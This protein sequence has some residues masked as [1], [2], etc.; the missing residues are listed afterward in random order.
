MKY[1]LT[2]ALATVLGTASSLSM[3]ADSP[4]ALELG[5]IEFPTTGP[6]IAQQHFLRGMLAMHSFWYDEA[7]DEFRAATT[8]VPSFAMGYWGEALSYYHPVWQDENLVGS[9]AA[10]AKVPVG[11]HLT[12]RE[13]EFIDAAKILFGDG[14]RDTRWN[15]DT[16]ALR[17]LHERY[18]QDDEAATLCA[19]ALL[20][21]KRG[22]GFRPFAEAAGLSLDVLQHNP[23][24]PGAAHYVIHAFDDPEHAILALPAARR[25]AQIA[26]EAYHARHMP[27]HIFVQLGM[28]KEAQASNE[29][30]LG[31][32]G[33][34]RS[35]KEARY[36]LLRFS[37][38]FVA[39]V[40][41]TRARPAT[42]CR[43]SARERV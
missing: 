15:S 25:Y 28:W 8:S 19:V 30:A 42:T 23:D 2:V 14:D 5:R 6:K 32:V 41:F 11:A 20:G 16:T 7:R 43:G 38:P 34:R 13:R 26:P 27:S 33:A 12:D 1:M 10:M 17:K 37:Q 3:A 21:A 22:K 35:Q 4:P 18:P 9:R 40:D 39:D 31:R 36:Q 29:A 24:H